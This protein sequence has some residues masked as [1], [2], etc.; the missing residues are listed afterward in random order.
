MSYETFLALC[1]FAFV[2]SITPG[3]SNIM[4][5]ASGANFGFVRTM[6]QVFGIAIGFNTLLLGIGLGLGAVL[7]AY[8]ALHLGLKIAGGLYLLYL[9]WRIGA[10]RSQSGSHSMGR[11]LRLVESATFQWV[12]PKAWIV[13]VAAMAIYTNPETPFFSA[14][15]VSLAFALMS[16]PSLMAWAC[17]GMALRQFLSKPGRLRTFNLAMGLLLIA[18]LWPLLR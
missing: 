9:A 2:T 7:S 10:A 15:L 14:I 1:V 6:P 3:P 18:T 17:F 4:L 11:P 13:A 5:L 8:P 16:L 12:N